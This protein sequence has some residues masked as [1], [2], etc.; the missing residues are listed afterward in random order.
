VRALTWFLLVFILI[1]ILTWL[2]Y[3]TRFQLEAKIW[4][5]RH[6]YS[7]TLGNYEV[8]VPDHWRIDDSDGYSS[9]SMR[10]TTRP[11]RQKNK[12][13]VSAGL[14]LFTSRG[15]PVSPEGMAYWLSNSRQNLAREGVESVEEK[16]LK[17][18]DQSLTCIGGR[19][20]SAMLKGAPALP[21]I[22]ALSFEC[23]SPTGLTILFTGEPSDIPAFE[24]WV[25]QIRKKS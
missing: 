8:P 16:T 23:S 6:G 4:H 9:L 2:W 12:L 3:A 24:L 25:S 22:T 15:R 1:S 21:E 20:L 14:Y 18:G 11:P 7:T 10:N 17:F 13:R 5:W 19:Q